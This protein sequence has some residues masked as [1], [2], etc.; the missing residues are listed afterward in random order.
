M[1][2]YD[3]FAPFYDSVMG[4]RK[5]TFSFIKQLIGKYQPDAKTILELACGTG[6][7]LKGLVNDYQVTGLDA[8]DKMLEIAKRKV[9]SGTFHRG[10]MSTFQLG[11]TFDV[12]VCV[13]NSINH[14]N[15]WSQWKSLFNQ[16]SKHLNKGGLFVFD[17]NTIDRLQWFSEQL[18]QAEKFD[19]NFIIMNFEKI[20]DNSYNLPVWIFEYKEGSEYTMH[21]E[22]IVEISF[23]IAQVQDALQAFFAIQEVIE[24]SGQ[25]ASD[26]SKKLAYFVCLKK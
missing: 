20:S 26:Q 8:S 6:S 9:P 24:I 21:K 12:I 19:Q 23:P 10:D 18:M 5:E 1:T 25:P 11:R 4:D 17:M 13:F 16:T 15:D 2:D 22:A 3:I 7:I 14:L